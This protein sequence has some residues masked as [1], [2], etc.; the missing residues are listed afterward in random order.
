M[1]QAVA[2]PTVSIVDE[3]ATFRDGS[4]RVRLAPVVGFLP[5]RELSGASL[6]RLGER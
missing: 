5:K 3:H 2:R 1:M 6:A 4:D